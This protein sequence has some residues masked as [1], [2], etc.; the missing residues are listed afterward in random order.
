M[1][2]VSVRVL[3]EFWEQDRRAEGAF[4]EWIVTVRRARWLNPVDVK[5]SF[6][7]ADPV[8]DGRMV[9][10]LAGNRF[11]IVAVIRYGPAI[12]YIRFVGAHA[13]YDRIDARKV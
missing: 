7:S 10:D 6:N 13:A 3:R 8:G 4:K 9:F 11:R 5:R 12:V 2:I 1:R